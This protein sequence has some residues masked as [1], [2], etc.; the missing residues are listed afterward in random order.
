LVLVLGAAAR[1]WLGAV[2]GFQPFEIRF[3][4]A[5]AELVH[6]IGDFRVE[7]A[8]LLAVDD[9]VLRF[10]DRALCDVEIGPLLL[11]PVLGESFGL[12]ASDR[13]N[14]VAQIAGEPE[15]LRHGPRLG[16]GQDHLP[17]LIGKLPAD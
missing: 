10:G 15:V 3:R 13:R 2:E 9:S 16:M 12:V 4:R 8:A 6:L 11:V 17:Q 1:G 7:V 14:R 5:R